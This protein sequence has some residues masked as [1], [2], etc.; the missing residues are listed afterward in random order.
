MKRNSGGLLAQRPWAVLG[1]HWVHVYMLHSVLY[2]CFTTQCQVWTST[3]PFENALVYIPCLD[4]D[5]LI[6]WQLLQNTYL[7]APCSDTECPTSCT[8]TKDTGLTSPTI[9]GSHAYA[10]RLY[11]VKILIDIYCV[12]MKYDES[13]MQRLIGQPCGKW[14]NLS[15][16]CRDESAGLSISVDILVA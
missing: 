4:L 7:A 3:L 1:G 2:L 8:I 15:R 13:E 12:A 5:E 11:V 10:L 6:I 16:A 14:Y 9:R